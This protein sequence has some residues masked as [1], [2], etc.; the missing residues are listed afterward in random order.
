MARDRNVS[1]GNRT[2]YLGCWDSSIGTAI[3]WMAR[4]KFLAGVR[5]FSLFSNV[6]TGSGSHLYSYPKGTTGSFLRDEVVG[7]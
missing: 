7:V 5:D 3:G 4:V 2:K 6:Q 1:F